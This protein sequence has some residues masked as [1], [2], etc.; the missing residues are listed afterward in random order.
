MSDD[1]QPTGQTRSGAFF[2]QEG[3]GGFVHRAFTKSMGFDDADI[4]KPVIGIC[5][6]YSEVNNCNRHLREIAE[7]VKRGVW[8]AGGLPLEFPTIS[9]GE[10]YLSPTSMLYRNLAAMDTEE[11]IRGQ[12]LDGVVL[13]VGCDKTVSAALLGLA[14]ADLPAI[15]VSGG[16]ML[17]GNY[18]GQMLGACTD[19]RRLTDEFRAGNLDAA[20]Y[21]QMEDS[22]VRSTGHCMVM[23]TASTMNSL[24][25][26]LGM[27]LPGNGATPAP[28]SRR[29]RLAEAAGRRIVDLVH[30]DVRPSQILTRA[31]FENAIALL[32]AIGGSTN[33]VVHLPAIAGRLGIDLPL[34]LFDAISRRTPVIAN[35]RPSGQ[36][37]MEDLFYAG[38]IPAVLAQLLPLLHGDALTVTGRTIAEN[39]RDAQIAN[40][41]VIRT[42]EQPLQPEGGIVVLRGNL[43][44]DGAVVKQSAATPRL[45]QH[46]GR[47]VVFKSIDDLAARA[48]DPDLDVTPDDVLVLQGAGPVGGPGMP[49]VGNLPIPLKLLKQGVRDMVRISDAR[50]SGTAY[51]TIVLHVA[52][53]SAVGGPLALVRD[54]DQIELD[55]PSRRLHL[56]VDEAELARRRAEWQ[57]PEPAYTRG[58]GRLFLDRVTQ[59]PQGC[60]FDFLRGASPVQR[61]KQ[62]KF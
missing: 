31:A 53:E 50:M 55:V 19:C 36:Y 20:T 24:T 28:D 51:G 47:A 6:T 52:P 38:G 9:L 30:E 62:P 7:A 18:R 43:A 48:N 58:Y 34:E 21:K 44:P 59:A 45:L 39:A 54:G 25:E 60:D 29:L 8:Q 23:G 17:S 33:A 27:A 49:E 56:Q 13:L 41:D 26:A 16:P 4:G 40:P 5:N 14:S 32:N 35:M 1:R 57:P 12:P 22:L 10:I 42:L 11:M 3:V 2:D 15:M 37:Q 61:P 46:R